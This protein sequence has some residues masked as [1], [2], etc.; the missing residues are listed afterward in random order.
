MWI[1]SSH[2]NRLVSD[3][4]IINNPSVPKITRVNLQNELRTR[5][6]TCATCDPVPALSAGF[7]TTLKIKLR[8]NQLPQGETCELSYPKSNFLESWGSINQIKPSQCTVELCKKNE[9]AI[10]NDNRREIEPRLRKFTPHC[11]TFPVPW[12][13]FRVN[14]DHLCFDSGHEGHILSEHWQDQQPKE[15]VY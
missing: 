4:F 11:F 8:R 6:K 5:F 12:W 13:C 7:A 3:S 14:S 1:S 15:K 2:C 9:R 10:K